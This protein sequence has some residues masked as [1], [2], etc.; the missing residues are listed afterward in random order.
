VGR[1]NLSATRHFATVQDLRTEVENARV[2]A[3]LHYRFSTV[4]GVQLGKEVAD[5]ELDPPSTPA[6]ELSE[7]GLSAAPAIGRGTV[8]VGFLR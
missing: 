6:A 1:A 5:Y 8:S 2:R 4:A 3:G 7:F